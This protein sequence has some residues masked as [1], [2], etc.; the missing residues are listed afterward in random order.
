[1]VQAICVDRYQVNVC[2]IAGC[3]TGKVKKG[4]SLPPVDEPGGGGRAVRRRIG[5]VWLTTR[6]RYFFFPVVCFH[7]KPAC[8]RVF[9]PSS[10]TMVSGLVCVVV[11]ARVR[12]RQAWLHGLLLHDLPPLYNMNV[13]FQ[14]ACS[15][16]VRCTT[17]PTPSSWRRDDE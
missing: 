9:S 8:C 7:E 17:A 16:S 15:S 12:F 5:P 4:R 2:Q 10:M 1:M 13:D 3:E 6:L 11:R 14:P